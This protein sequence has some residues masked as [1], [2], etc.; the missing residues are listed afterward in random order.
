M[1]PQ[2]K[3]GILYAVAAFGFWGLA[4]IYFIPNYAIEITNLPPN[5]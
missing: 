1:N 4:P 2:Q 3:T 5:H